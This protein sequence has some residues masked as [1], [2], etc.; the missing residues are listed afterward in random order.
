MRRHMK[1]IVVFGASGDVGRY[2]IDYLL[3]NGEKYDIFAIGRREHLS[4]FDRNENVTYLSVDI[5][6]KTEFEK[7]PDDI[8]AVVDFAGIMPA[9]MQGYHPQQ[10]IDVNI[11]GTLNILEYARYAHADRV[12]FM[13]SFG[14]I[15]DYGE[16]D[17]LLTAHMPRKFSF[18]T[19]HTIYVMSKNFAVDLLENYHQMYG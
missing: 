8:Y 3:A 18:N 17:V 14:D 11:T 4:I 13:Q 5:R 10:Y 12:L 15:K 6:N 1:K 9:R 2:F 7:L 19:D 16:T